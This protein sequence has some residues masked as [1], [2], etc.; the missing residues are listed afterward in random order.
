M[1]SVFVLRRRDPA[2]HV[3]G[4]PWTALVF[5]ALVAVLL[6]LLA[7]SNPLQAL[8]GLGLVAAALPVYRI[9]EA[10]RAAPEED[11]P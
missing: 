5:L 11:T 10:R 9:I 1:A 8:L 6:T 4:H 3:P 2:F 7:L